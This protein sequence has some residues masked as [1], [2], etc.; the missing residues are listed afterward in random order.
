MIDFQRFKKEY[1]EN[2]YSIHK[3]DD[4][5]IRKDYNKFQNGVTKAED[6]A[7]NILKNQGFNFDGLIN[8]IFK[9][10]YA[11]DEYDDILLDTIMTYLEDVY[12]NE[13]I[14]GS[15]MCLKSNLIGKACQMIHNEDLL[16]VVRDYDKKY[17][18]LLY[19][20]FGDKEE[21]KVEYN[22]LIIAGQKNS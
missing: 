7:T 5:L 3:I 22:E 21:V 11:L 2:I 13:R 16:G 15:G 17:H 1:I 9:D 14:D 4:E 20:D 12:G 8:D 18:K 10:N 6:L 19:V